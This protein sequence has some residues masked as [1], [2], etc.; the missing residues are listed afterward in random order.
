MLCYILSLICLFL[1]TLFWCSLCC[2]DNADFPVV[3]LHVWSGINVF[4]MSFVIWNYIDFFYVFRDRQSWPPSAVQTQLLPWS[5]SALWAQQIPL[6]TFLSPHWASA[7]PWLWFTW[8]LKGT[9]QLRWHRSPFPL[10]LH[11]SLI[12][13]KVQHCNKEVHCEMKSP[14]PVCIKQD[15]GSGCWCV[16]KKG[17]SSGRWGSVNFE[18]M[19]GLWKKL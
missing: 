5:C 14:C 15:N 16:W 12:L 13:S 18:P 19:K 2:C 6:G 11:K 3:E 10:S 4:L 9:R 7:L 17:V 8:A 1:L